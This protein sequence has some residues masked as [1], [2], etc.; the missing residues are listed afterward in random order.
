[1]FLFKRKAPA[2]LGRTSYSQ[3]GEDLI[4]KFIF[5]QLQ[6]HH[7][8]YIDIGAHD[9]FYLSNTALFY[10]LG[11][12]GINIEPDPALF[13]TFA[14]HR[15]HDINLNI[16]IGQASGAAKFYIISNPT[17]NTFSKAEAEGY[18]REGPYIVKEVIDVP[19]ETLGDI[20]NRYHEGI[21]PDLL[22]LDAEGV[23]EQ[24]IQSINFQQSIPTVI[25]LETISFSSSGN[26]KKNRDLIDYVT[27]NGYLVYADTYINTIFVNKAVWAAQHK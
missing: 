14:N 26:G 17:L 22:N 19:V 3:C 25:C 6:I 24:I 10:Q 8:S 5:D 7:P 4:I 23:D 20:I 9:P 21:F 13:K 15:K 2:L 1:M 27:K 16:G 12:K 11:S 18:F